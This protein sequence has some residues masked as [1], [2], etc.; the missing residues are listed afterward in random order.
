[1]NIPFFPYSKL[2]SENKNNFQEIFDDVCSR[3]AYI[4]Q[5]DLEEF[6]ENIKRFIDT[7][8]VFGVANGTDALQL[9][10]EACEIREGDEIILPSHTYIASAASVHFAKAKPVLTEC[11]QDNMMDTS[12]IEHRITDKTKAIMPVHINGRTCNMDEIARIAKEN[13][14]LIVEDAAQALGSKFKGKCA[15]TFGE[16]G[17]IS[18][19]PAKLL[20]CFGDGGLIV[21]NDDKIAE[22]LFL[23]RDH[24]RDHSGEVVAW[25]YNSRLDNMQAAFLNFKLKQYPKEIEHRRYIAKTYDEGL[26]DLPDLT[27]PLPP[28]NGDNFDV[29]Q[30]YELQAESR[31]D[32]KEYLSEKGIGT[33]IQ[34]AGTPVHQFKKLGF[35]QQLPKT[36][37]FFDKCLMLPMNASLDEAEVEYIISTIRNF[38]E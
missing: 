15:G 16:F 14:L 27:L 2:Y 35:N 9:G 18:L 29:Y 7:K 36:D 23:L 12:D 33:I 26:R 28:N 11:G 24:G 21:T 8:H 20:G 19:Y 5:K 31:D 22:K 25:G 32:L 34:W 30:N 3:G 4:M 37:L 13:D 6:E 1:M 10:L 17:T 38:Y